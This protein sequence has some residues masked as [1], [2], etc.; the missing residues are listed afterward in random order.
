MSVISRSVR[1]RR[2][3][4]TRM[5]TPVSWRRWNRWGCW[6]S[7]CLTATSCAG[8][9]WAVRNRLRPTPHYV[10]VSSPRSFPTTNCAHTPREAA[11]SFSSSPILWISDCKLRSGRAMTLIDDLVAGM[12]RE[13]VDTLDVDII[14]THYELKNGRSV[15]EPLVDVAEVASGEKNTASTASMSCSSCSSPR[16]MN[17]RHVSTAIEVT[18]APRP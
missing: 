3:S 7:A 2:C 5:P 12:P 16:S 9:S 4:S 17:S 1:S 6:R 10:S 13:Y 15:A 11:G 8:L 14:A 18:P